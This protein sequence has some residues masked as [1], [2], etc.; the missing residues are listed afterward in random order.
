MPSAREQIFVV[1][2]TRLQAIS[3]VQEYEREPSAD[4]AKF[5]ALHVEDQGQSPIGEEGGSSRKALIF[6]VRGYVKGASGAGAHAVLNELHAN[7]VKTLMTEPPLGGIVELIE[8][9]G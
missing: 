7:V 9:D 5:S 4:P 1:V 3:G 8:E 2:D 6:T